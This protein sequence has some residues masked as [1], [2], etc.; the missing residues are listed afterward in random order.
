MDVYLS[1]LF[2]II[3]SLLKRRLQVK[4]TF[5]VITRIL[6]LIWAL[7]ASHHYSICF[8]K[9]FLTT[10][11][12]FTVFYWCKLHLTV[13][14]LT[15]INRSNPSAISCCKLYVITKHDSCLRQYCKGFSK[16][17]YGWRTVFWYFFSVR[18]VT[19][20]SSFQVYNMRLVVAEWTAQEFL[21]VL[22]SFFFSYESSQESC[23]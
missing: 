20:I 3:F 8:E 10:R 7:R 13:P 14:L 17:V 5:Q 19:K 2:H 22:F 18:A 23:S 16:N 6:V 11:D 12:Q 4:T 9:D 1:S 21:L 15:A